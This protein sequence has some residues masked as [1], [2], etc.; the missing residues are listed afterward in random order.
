[1]KISG[2]KLSRAG[3]CVSRCPRIVPQHVAAD[4]DDRLARIAAAEIESV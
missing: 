3:F 1:L 2:K 4:V